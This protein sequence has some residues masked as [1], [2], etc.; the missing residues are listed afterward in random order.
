MNAGDASLAVGK[1]RV[2]NLIS[3][4]IVLMEKKRSHDQKCSHGPET[5]S[6][7]RNALMEQIRN[8]LMEQKRSHGVET[9]S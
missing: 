3:W 8:V 9:F 6:W 7:S 4:G 2:L 5:F 1:D